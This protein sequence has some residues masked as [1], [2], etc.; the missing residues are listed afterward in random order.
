M[1]DSLPIRFSQFLY[2]NMIARFR[3]GVFCLV[4]WLIISAAAAAAE[5]TSI[6][7]YYIPDRNG[8]PLAAA[9]EAGNQLWKQRY[10]PYGY[11]DESQAPASSTVLNRIG[12]AGHAED[13]LP[14]LKLV[15]MQARFYDPAIGRFLGMDPRAVDPLNPFSFNRYAYAN[16]NPYAYVD[17]NGEIAFLIPFA[18]FVAKEI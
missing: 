18:I 7:T 13:K 11:T 16:N 4:G 8:S 6:K 1:P 14:D 2:S 9:D 15:Y 10:T 17:R 5:V 3:F 12:F